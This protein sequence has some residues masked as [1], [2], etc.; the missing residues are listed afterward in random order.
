MVLVTPEQAVEQ[1]SVEGLYRRYARDVFSVAYRLVGSRA[2]AEDV[3]QTTF[4]NAHRAL[5]DGV[6]PT[7]QRAWLLTIARNACRSRY[8]TLRR[9]PREEPLDESLFTPLPEED[10]SASRVTDALR[11]LLPRQRAALVMQAV[12]GCST[13]EIGRSS[14]SGP[15]RSMPSSSVPEQP[16]VTSC[17][18]TWSS[19]AAAESKRS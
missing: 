8:R 4:L 16:S 10:E 6:E 19:W 3:T 13:A 2:E 11:A 12:D 1:P 14:D 18:R 5:L 17:G 15:L 9:R 7:D